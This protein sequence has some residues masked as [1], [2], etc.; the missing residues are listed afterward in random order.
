MIW[1]EKVA[2]RHMEHMK[3]AVKAFGE[4]KVY[5]A[6]VFNMFYGTYQIDLGIDLYNARDHFDFLVSVAFLTPNQERIVYEDLFYAGSVVRFLKSM[7]PEKEAII[8]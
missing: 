8:L 3:R 6:E 4:D 5:T 7:A 1:K 2:D